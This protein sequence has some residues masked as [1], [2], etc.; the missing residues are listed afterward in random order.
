[1]A[2]KNKS[3]N[4]KK[5]APYTPNP[6]DKKGELFTVEDIR[7]MASVEYAFSADSLGRKFSVAAAYAEDIID[8]AKDNGLNLDLTL[9]TEQDMYEKVIPKL[10]LFKRGQDR[11]DDW[12]REQLE[13]TIAAYQLFLLC[14]FVNEIG[15]KV[16]FKGTIEQVKDSGLGLA[17]MAVNAKSHK[18][19]KFNPYAVLKRVSEECLTF[20]NN[21]TEYAFTIAPFR[22]EVE[23]K[24]I[25][26]MAD[27][28]NEEGA[29]IS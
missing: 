27:T 8:M 29:D 17:V 7:K 4:K 22:K 5:K 16:G 10:I 24:L 3:K 15:K 13:K 19:A 11:G 12:A 26:K 18:S 23:E 14:N 6:G 25:S 1:M 20:G 9:E 21:P 2:S 28:L